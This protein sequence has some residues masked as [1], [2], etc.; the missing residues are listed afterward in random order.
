MTSHQQSPFGTGDENNPFGTPATGRQQ[1]NSEE[2]TGIGENDYRFGGYESDDRRNS[3]RIEV[4]VWRA[5]W[6]LLVSAVLTVIA[7]ADL[8]FQVT[9]RY[10]LGRNVGTPEIVLV[11]LAVVMAVVGAV[12]ALRSYRSG[13][14]I[15]LLWAV[16]C[17]VLLLHS[18][19]WVVSLLAVG[20]AVLAWLPPSRRWT[21]Y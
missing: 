8:V 18:T 11:T 19:R 6:T 15:L 1:Q 16:L 3:A 20:A 12:L 14:I 13:R 2:F 5:P 4:P 17:L 9:N 21:D 7:S 10:L